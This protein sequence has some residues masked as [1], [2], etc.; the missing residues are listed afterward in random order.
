MTDLETSPETGAAGLSTGGPDAARHRQLMRDRYHDQLDELDRRVEQMG[1]EVVSAIAASVEALEALDAARAQALIE[2]DAHIDA[3][4]H[5]IDEQAFYLLATQQPTARDLR[6]LTAISSITAELERI[7]DHCSGIAKLTLTL[8]GEPKGE[9]SPAIREMATITEELLGRSLKAF[10]DRDV[11][12]A[13]GIWLR[14]DEVDELYQAFFKQQID[15][16]V[17][18][19]KRVRR[20]TYMLWVAHNIERMADRV[21]NIAEATAFVA[22]G[23]VAGWRRQIEEESVPPSF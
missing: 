14:D 4:R 13:A 19:R 5:E 11:Q 23:D 16:M 9:P 21:T 6:L 22:T 18:H 10:A 15:E 1:S 20:G 2:G 7:G 3:M 17:N 12:A 8:A